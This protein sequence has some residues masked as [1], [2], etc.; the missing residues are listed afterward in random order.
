MAEGTLAEPTYVAHLTAA[1]QQDLPD[2]QVRHEQVRHNRYRF[3]VLSER[4]KDMG[5]PER[6]R[7]VWD[8]A[9][10][11]LDKPDLLNVAMILTVAPS[12]YPDTNIIL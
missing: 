11:A 6:Q 4:F 10:A 12:D 3:I 8:I 7:I 5:H 9:D 1:L 2:A